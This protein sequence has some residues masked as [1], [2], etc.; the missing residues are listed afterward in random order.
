MSYPELKQLQ[1]A[2]PRLSRVVAA[3][4][5][6][7]GSLSVPARSH[8]SAGT[9]AESIGEPRGTVLGLLM[10]AAHLGL[11]KL[12]FRLTCP[13]TGAGIRDYDSLDDI[14]SEISCDVCGNVHHITT[15]DVEYF[16][17]LSEANASARR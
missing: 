13:E 14:P 9:V 1:K 6:Y 3:I 15:D 8:I 17:E 5:K 2:N 11:L 16:F 4:D 7:L 10:A 12:K